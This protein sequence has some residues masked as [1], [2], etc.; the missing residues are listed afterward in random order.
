VELWREVAAVGAVFGL[1][2]AAMWTLRGRAG[3][4][5][6]RAGKSLTAVERIALTPHH[7]LHLIRAR[8][9][10]LLVATH[11]QGCTLLVEQP[12]VEQPPVEQP[13]VEQAFIEQALSEP[14]L[15]EWALSGPSLPGTARR[16]ETL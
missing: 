2:G 5:G 6:T 4:I 7:T 1:L 10:E 16:V 15:P 12:L 8:G 14:A 9:R 3:M 11:P 13:L